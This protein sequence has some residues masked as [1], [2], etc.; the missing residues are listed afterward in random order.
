MGL[1]GVRPRRAL[2]PWSASSAG[3]R[4]PSRPWPWACSDVRHDC[5]RQAASA[6]APWPSSC[7]HSRDFSSASALA[8]S[9]A[10]PE[11]PARPLPPLPAPSQAQPP[12]RRP[13]QSMP[14][15]C[16]FCPA[17]RRWSC[18]AQRQAPQAAPQTTVLARPRSRLRAQRARPLER[19]SQLADR[20]WRWA[21]R[22]PLPE[23]AR[24][25]ATARSCARCRLPRAHR[26]L[27]LQQPFRRSFVRTLVANSSASPHSSGPSKHYPVRYA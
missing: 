6:P 17:N 12:P 24:S 18:G 2:W 11:P 14:R 10:A 4:P 27:L 8:L 3:C 7:R 21:R 20:H 26:L 13:P 5:R 16:A 19:L 1:L 23:P 15:T 25:R 22:Q 9:C